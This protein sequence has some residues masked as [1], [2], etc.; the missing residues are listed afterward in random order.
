MLEIQNL[1]QRGAEGI[2]IVMESS[3]RIEA[4]DFIDRRSFDVRHRRPEEIT[5]DCGDTEPLDRGR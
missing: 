5:F 1:G 4:K 2:K 3:R